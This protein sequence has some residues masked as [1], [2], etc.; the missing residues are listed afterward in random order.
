[1]STNF[2]GI[3]YDVI[4]ELTLGTGIKMRLV[5]NI[6]SK[7]RAIQSWGSMCG[8]WIITSRYGNVAEEWA[9]WVKTV[10][11]IKDK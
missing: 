3:Q 11:S 2:F 4:E 1:M 6:K 8:E 10:N 9:G 5:E 7:R